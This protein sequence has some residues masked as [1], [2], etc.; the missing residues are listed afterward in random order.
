MIGLAPFVREVRIAWYLW[1][2]RSMG[3]LHPDFPEVLMRLH[4][5]R[6]QRPPVQ[7]TPCPPFMCAGHP[8]CPDHRCP[9][10]ARGLHQGDGGMEVRG[11][12]SFP[13]ENES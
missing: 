4:E 9:G 5:L 2:A 11:A 1:A 8:D 7:R 13:I 10:R 12:L 6:A 3:P